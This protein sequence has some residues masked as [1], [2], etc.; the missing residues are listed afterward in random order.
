MRLSG[1]NF[2]FR[3]FESQLDWLSDQTAVI[4]GERRRLAIQ[5][6]EVKSSKVDLECVR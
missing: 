2:L 1:N 5:Q 6:S 4:R 3:F